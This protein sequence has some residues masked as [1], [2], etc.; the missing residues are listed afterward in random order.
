M[1]VAGCQAVLG[2]DDREANPP[3]PSGCALP[4][5]GGGFL[6]VA[7]WV[8]SSAH[9]DFCVRASGTSWARPILLGGGTGTGTLCT[10]GFSYPD[11]SAPF[12]VPLGKIDVKA[13]PAGTNC[14][15]PDSVKPLSE[16]DGLQTNASAP[17]LVARI[18][19]A[20]GVPEKLVAYGSAVAPAASDDTTARV[21]F[22]HAAVG[23][24]PL[25]FGVLDQGSLPATLQQ[26][27][28]G[29]LSFG[30]VSNSGTPNLGKLDG[31][32]LDIPAAPML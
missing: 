13:I 2:L 12:R 15:G 3:P 9:V 28:L 19:G 5:V 26:A 7:T 30:Q 1:A 29:P 18:G 27:V 20:S 24:K 10:S 17:V 31:F 4:S 21:R 11:V 6:R 25:T 22:I 14:S 32:Y 8:P 16:I 23:V